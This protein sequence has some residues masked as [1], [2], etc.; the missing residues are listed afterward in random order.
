VWVVCETFAM[1]EPGSSVENSS[2]KVLA[3]SSSIGSKD[4]KLNPN[5]Y[6]TWQQ[7]SDAYAALQSKAK[8]GPVWGRVSKFGTG[9]ACSA[10]CELQC[11]KCEPSASYRSLRRGPR[12]V[13]RTLA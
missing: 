5:T 2:E 6:K 7:A 3:A 4:I 9:D 11:K 12:I 8:S 13:R 10:D 1:S